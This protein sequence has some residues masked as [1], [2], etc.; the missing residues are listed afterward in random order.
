MEMLVYKSISIITDFFG[1]YTMSAFEL[2]KGFNEFLCYDLV[3]E[4]PNDIMISHN[5]L[6]AHRKQIIT[7]N[8]NPQRNYL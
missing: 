7:L 3:N 8:L 4:V 5:K 6:E 2:T 1:N